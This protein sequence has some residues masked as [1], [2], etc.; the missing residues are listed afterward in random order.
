MGVYADDTTLYTLVRSNDCTPTQPASLHHSLTALHAWGQ[1]WKVPF[2]PTKSK[3]MTISRHQLQWQL[4]IS[5][6]GDQQTISSSCS[7]VCSMIVYNTGLACDKS[8]CK[9][10]PDSAYYVRLPSTLAQLAGSRPTVGL[11]GLLLE[12]APLARMGA[13]PTHL[14]QLDRVQRRALH[15]I[16]PDAILQ[17]LASC[18]HVA[19]LSFL[20]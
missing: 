20:L 4:P 12:Y 11:S 17:S 3:C 19:D 6:S 9:P 10:I 8:H 5:V 16:G 15:I 14:H 18:Q 1:K 13:A 2:E 7:V